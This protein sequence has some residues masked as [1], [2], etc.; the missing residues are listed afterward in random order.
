MEP[1]IIAVDF[2]GTIVCHKF[3][4]I[5]KA[6]PLAIETM[7][8]WQKIGI[9]IILWTVRSGKYLDDA[10]AWCKEHGI[11]FYG[12]NENPYQKS[13]STSPKAFAQFYVDDMAVGC[14][15]MEFEGCK[16]VDW[17][18]VKGIIGC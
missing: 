11:E 6:V 14:P 16:V 8:E 2:D 13:W 1:V 15:L 18:K 4:N 7:K 9:N 5:G 12:I 17:V 3:P 10:V